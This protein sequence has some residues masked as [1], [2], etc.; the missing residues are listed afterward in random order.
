MEGGGEGEGGK[1]EVEKA[2]AGK[3]R[4]REITF[5]KKKEEKPKGEKNR[6]AFYGKECQNRVR[7]LGGGAR[8]ET[9][10]EGME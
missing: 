8:K 6:G 9:T 4:R 10:H 2:Y 7:R 5:K 3:G 1:G